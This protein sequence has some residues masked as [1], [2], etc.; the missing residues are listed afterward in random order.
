MID[1]VVR[2]TAVMAPSPIGKALFLQRRLS[3]VFRLRLAYVAFRARQIGR[4]DIDAF[5]F[6]GVL[7][8]ACLRCLCPR[9]T[10]GEPTF[11]RAKLMKNARFILRESSHES[12]VLVS[13]FAVLAN[14]LTSDDMELLY[15]LEHRCLLPEPCC[16]EI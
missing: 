4:G 5:F 1:R 13:L 12:S 15:W 10:N 2:N 7:S 8:E 14:G 11:T 9:F 3:L 6:V 16:H